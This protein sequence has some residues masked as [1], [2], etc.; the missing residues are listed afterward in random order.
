M[1]RTDA[2]AATMIDSNIDAWCA[3]RCQG[4]SQEV[5][6]KWLLPTHEAG[7]K[8]D[9]MQ[10]TALLINKTI[11]NNFFHVYLKKIPHNSKK[12]VFEHPITIFIMLIFNAWFYSHMFPDLKVR[13]WV[14]RIQLT[15]HTSRVSP[16]GG[17]NF[18]VGDGSYE[19]LY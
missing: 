7:K 5:D 9:N 4:C 8:R 3:Y 16:S 18:G 12:R 6:E 15:I 13:T 1:A 2:E 14:P 10:L 11:F 19:C 17:P